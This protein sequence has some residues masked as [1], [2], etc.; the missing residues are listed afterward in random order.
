LIIPPESYPDNIDEVIPFSENML[1]PAN[2]VALMGIR[3]GTKNSSQESAEFADPEKFWKQISA[4][5]EVRAQFA[6]SRSSTGASIPRYFFISLE[7]H[8]DKF[9]GATAGVWGNSLALP[10]AI[11]D[12][13]RQDAAELKT[14]RLFFVYYNRGRVNAAETLWYDLSI[15]RRFR[16]VPV[17]REGLPGSQVVRVVGS[18]PLELP[19]LD[20]KVAEQNK[21]A[22]RD[23]QKALLELSNINENAV[24][25]KLH[26]LTTI[27]E[28]LQEKAGMTNPTIKL[29]LH[30]LAFDY[31]GSRRTHPAIVL[32]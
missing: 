21:R 28:D 8:S 30:V 24:P 19:I 7:G 12:L 5:P 26:D 3:R 11:H 27:I 32:K 15:L 13:L 17:Y 9:G 29:V 14:N 10:R 2:G 6:A 25:G 31:E 22:L 18:C 1:Y 20:E 4:S 23:M 16:C